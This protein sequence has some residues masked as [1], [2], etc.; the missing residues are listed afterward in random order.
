MVSKSMTRAEAKTA[1][2]KRYYTGEACPEGH[3]ADRFTSNGGCVVCSSNARKQFHKENKDEQNVK[4]MVRYGLNK[5]RENLNSKDRYW[6]NPTSGRNRIKNWRLKNPEKAAE[7][8]LVRV[9][10]LGDRVPA[11]ADR[12]KIKAVYK[13]AKERRSAGEDVHV[14][15]EIPLHGKNVC[16]LH[17]HS[18]LRIIPGSVNLAKSN[19]WGNQ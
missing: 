3:F 13:E 4:R 2:V 14:D 10:H 16:G 15:H 12:E 11:W 18:N 8:T 5:D 17:I 9:R 7:N 6:A 1:G 19:Q